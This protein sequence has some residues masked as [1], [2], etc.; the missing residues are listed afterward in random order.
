MKTDRTYLKVELSKKEFEFIKFLETGSNNFVEAY[1]LYKSRKLHYRA[2]LRVITSWFNKTLDSLHKKK[3]CE[4]VPFIYKLRDGKYL[5]SN[6]GISSNK[7]DFV[8]LTLQT[9]DMK[10][11]ALSN[12]II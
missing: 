8:A 12:K 7:A 3:L 5:W 6:P 1:F 4:N 11:Y 9:E 10:F 2:D